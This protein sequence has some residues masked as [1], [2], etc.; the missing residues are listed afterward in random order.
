MTAALPD[1]TGQVIWDW[2]GLDR[3]TA[4]PHTLLH[5]PAPPPPLP[6]PTCLPPSCCA[7]Y[8]HAHAPAIPHSHHPTRLWAHLHSACTLQPSSTP[9]LSRSLPSPLPGKGPDSHTHPPLLYS[10][11]L[12]TKVWAWAGDLVPFFTPSICDIPLPP[13][14]LHFCGTLFVA[15]KVLR[16]T[17]IP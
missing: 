7:C 5:F 11:G 12:P 3:Q 17:C 14:A 9:S 2:T 15:V 8:Y 6:L 13:C 1:R 4:P 10:I 16:G